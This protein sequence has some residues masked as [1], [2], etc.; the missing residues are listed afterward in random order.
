MNEIRLMKEPIAAKHPHTLVKHGDIRVDDY[1]WLN[2]K[3]N[4]DVISYLEAEND[5]FKESL[6]HTEALQQTLLDE[7][8]N[9]LV[10]DDASAPVFDNGFYYYYKFAKNKEYPIY[11]RYA[12]SKADEQILL[13][14]NELARPHSYYHVRELRVSPDNQIM[15]FAEDTVSRRIYTLKFVKLINGQ[16]LSDCIPDTTGDYVWSNN[17]Q[18]VFYTLREPQTL[19]AY[20]VMKHLIGTPTEQDQVVYEE[21][22]P[23]FMIALNKSRSGKFIFINIQA[24][25]STETWLIDADKPNDNLILFQKREHAHEYIIDHQEDRFFILT[26]WDAQNFRL[27]SCA[28]NNTVKESW[29]EIVPV[30]TD[31]LLESVDAFYHFIILTERKEGINKFRIIF[32]DGTEKY[33]TFD[34]VAYMAYVGSNFRYD[35]QAIRLVYSSPSTPTTDYDYDIKT[36]K[37]TIIKEKQIPGN[38]DKQNYKVI[39]VFAFAE[40]GVKIP[41]T[42]FYN[43]QQVKLKEPSPLLLYGYGSY[44]YSLDAYFNSDY[45]SLMD[46]GMIIALAHIRGGQ[47]M[48]RAW[49]DDGKLLKKM[50][51]F[52]DFIKCAEQLIEDGYTIP[53]KLM[54]MGGSAGGLLMGVIVNLRPDLFRA[55]VSAVPFV[56]V[57]TTM[58]DE[59]IPLTT[60]EYDEWGNPND[61]I[62][63]EYMKSYSPYDNLQA[64]SYPAILV[65]AGLH[66][67][68]VQYWEPAK[69]VAKLRTVKSNN[70]P[71]Y[72]YTEMAAGHSGASGRYQRY[73]ETSKVYAF[74]LDQIE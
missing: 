5:Y 13:D 33:I 37:L 10:P 15:G 44:G 9:R 17:G 34:E 69:Y 53:S 26:N 25:L 59:T 67:S 39:R 65:T 61:P 72:L 2:Q 7:L 56:D 51:T 18:I 28:V 70:N 57:V 6:K 74:L 42:L 22:D 32:N 23:T 38:F 66:D 4:P 35:P 48:G 8:R 71:V 36:E 16:Y 43:K 11:C 12:E 55:I 50:N 52:T 1:Y 73:Y 64:Q 29:K 47:E 30:K 21:K 41:I 24:T 3:E 58:L 63:Y 54:A 14:V 45:L 60:F 27:M 46:R 20:K 19:R 40:D 49:Y 68:Q 31:V 62:Y